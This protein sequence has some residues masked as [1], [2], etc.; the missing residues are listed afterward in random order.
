MVL[1]YLLPRQDAQD[2]P[3]PMLVGTLHYMLKGCQVGLVG[4]FAAGMLWGVKKT[5]SAGVRALAHEA[6]KFMVN[7][8]YIG[9]VG[10]IFYNFT[11]MVCRSWPQNREWTHSMQRSVW[12][13]RLDACTIGGALVGGTLLRR[14]QMWTRLIGVEGAWPEVWTWSGATAL[15]GSIAW[16]AFA[17]IAANL[18]TV[19][20]AT[21][22]DEKYE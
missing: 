21:G 15:P 13:N 18:A 6:T 19:G 7:F 11:Q 20:L 14:T 9:G 10:G 4:G 8:G 5:P 2:I 22:M 1:Y 3:A 17:G 12:H 16:G